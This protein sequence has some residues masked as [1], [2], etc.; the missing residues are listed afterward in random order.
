VDIGED[1]GGDGGE[2]GLGVDAWGGV[3]TWFFISFLVNHF[4]TVIHSLISLHLDNG[5]YNH[6]DVR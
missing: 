5:D 4:G 6:D 1:P 3:D 2:G